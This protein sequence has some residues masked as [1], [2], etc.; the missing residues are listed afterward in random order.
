[1]LLGKPVVLIFISVFL[2]AVGQILMKFGTL[3]VRIIEGEPFLQLMFKYFTNFPILC[4]MAMYALSA[5]S[6]IFALSR[7]QLSYAY[8]MVAAGYVIVAVASYFLFGDT[9]SLLR[10]VGLAVILI[11]VILVAMS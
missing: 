11:G 6:W 2:G 10:I 1:M 3:R 8:P 7:A 4:G 5:V 9:L